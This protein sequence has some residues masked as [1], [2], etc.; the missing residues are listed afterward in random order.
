MSGWEDVFNETVEN[1]RGGDCG[2]AGSVFEELNITTTF[3]AVDLKD[4]EEWDEI[5]HTKLQN[6]DILFFVKALSHIPDGDK[7]Q[8]LRNV[9]TCM[10]L[11]SHL[12]YIDYPYPYRVFSSLSNHL[13][14]V[15]QAWEMR[16]FLG[17][18]DYA[19]GCSNIASSRAVVK[20]FARYEDDYS[21]LYF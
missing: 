7:L 6:A 1:L 3:I 21:S 13:R 12:I 11:E 15:Y 2:K 5:M 14:T 19:F 20:V 9:V 4:S 10:K 16:Y 17:H 8:V 18:K